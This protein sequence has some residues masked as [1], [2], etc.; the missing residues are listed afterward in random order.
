[1]APNVFLSETKK[2]QGIKNIKSKK[3]LNSCNRYRSKAKN[4]I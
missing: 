1:M 4:Y 3:K 2:S